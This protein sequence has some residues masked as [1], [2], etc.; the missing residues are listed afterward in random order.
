MTDFDL[1]D[2][3]IVVGARLN[4]SRLPGK[5]LLNLAGSPLIARIFERLTQI[6]ARSVLATTADPVN[7]ALV[8]WAS[9]S[10]VPVLA[11]RGDVNDVVSRVDEAVRL[12]DPSKVVYVCGDC[13]LV[14]AEYIDRALQALDSNPDW[15]QIIP[16]KRSDGQTVVHEG[17]LCLSR[18]GWD[19][20]VA[21]SRTSLEREHVG[22]ALAKDRVLKRGELEEADELYG[23]GFRLSVD[24]AADWRFMSELYQKWYAHRT[25]PVSLLWVME[26]LRNSDVSD[27]N[28]HVMQKS[29][30]RKYGQVL[31]VTEAG[32]DKGLGQLVRTVRLAER[33]CELA[34]LGTEIW[35]LGEERA[36]GFLKTVNHQWVESETQL[37][38]KL[39]EKPLPPLLVVDLF[40][41]RLQQPD[42]I[43]RLFFQFLGHGMSIVG[44]DRLWVWHDV[45][46]LVIVPCLVYHGC[47][48]ENI[49]AG[50]EYA[51]APVWRP[52]S[53]NRDVTSPV[54]TV[55]VGGADAVGY[56]TWLP[57]LLDKKLPAG[58]V[59]RWLQGPYA[60]APDLPSK[61][62]LDW[63]ILG[64]Q[65][66]IQRVAQNSDLVLSVY[67]NT[68]LELLANQ[69][70][71]VI[72]PAPGL[73]DD[74]EWSAM[75]GIEGICCIDLNEFG[76]DKLVQLISS[77][78]A[79]RELGASS[80]SLSAIGG[81]QRAAEAVLSTLDRSQSQIEFRLN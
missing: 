79:C 1:S 36:L 10:S 73:I 32:A 69:I 13:P 27:I 49:L 48:A 20:L 26:Q 50:P 45:L 47:E 14:S 41:E 75:A 67:G 71:V 56:G 74:Q 46:S 77:S 51:L 7:Q 81:L 63:H 78:E 54:V 59:C 4:S 33:M 28:A 12:Y 31:F 17:I 34:G 61:P 60:V 30:Y 57:A 62:N 5:H 44:L 23:S 64:P 25:G 42:A 43:Y 55:M 11:Y 6:P 19:Q 22:S 72:L 58:V 24:T 35:I 80:L 66:D 39:T 37:H 65:A 3:L 21:L 16:A 29:G 2:S 9:A 76:L 18:R 53:E 8:D 40:P 15:D 70:P 52:P 68:V 38:E